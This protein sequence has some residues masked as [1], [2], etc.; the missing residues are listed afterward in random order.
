MFIIKISFALVLS[1]IINQAW[2]QVQV[3]VLGESEITI[4]GTSTLHDWESYSSGLSGGGIARVEA[5]KLLGFDSFHLTLPAESILSGKAKMD[6]YTYKAL[7]SELF[8]NISFTMKSAKVVADKMQVVGDLTIAG[9]TLEIQLSLIMTQDN[10]KITLETEKTINMTD[11]N[12]SPPEL[13]MGTLKTGEEVTIE[14]KL[15]CN[16]TQ[17]NNLK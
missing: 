7:Q 9:N 8:P 12:I 13:F 6:N 15:Y 14:V 2:S 11:W 5:S 10:Q 16:I 4:K 17:S 3:T 1:F